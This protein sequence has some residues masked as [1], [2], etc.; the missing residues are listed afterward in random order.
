MNVRTPVS[1]EGARALPLWARAADL[2]AIALFL[3]GCY[4]A[5]EGGFVARA[6][7][8]RIAL[9]SEWR[10]FAWTA[11]FVLLRH[12][13]V[14][15]RPLWERLGDGLRRVAHVLAPRAEELWLADRDPAAARSRTW[16]LRYGAAIVL[17]FAA[18]TVLMTYPQVLGLDRAVTPDYGDPLLSTWR[19]AWFAHQLPHDPLHLFDANIFYPERF[20]L[21]FSDAM[22]VPS[23]MVAPLVWLG[24]PQLLAYNLLLLSAFALS[25]ATMFVLVRSLT[26]HT[27]AALVAGFI[28]AF[29]PYRFMHYAHL[30]LQMAQWMPLGLCALHR[31]FDRGRIRDGVLTG[32]FIALQTLSSIYYGI[33][34]AT[35]LVPV[36]AVLWFGAQP[37]A[38]RRAVK[39]LAIAVVLSGVLVAPLA[40]PYFAARKAVGERP[41]QEIE[42]YS[43][44][45]KNYLAAHSR[46]AL[47]G[48][49]TAKWGAQERELFQGIV[50]PALA[51]VALWPP[52]STARLAY[53]AGLAVAFDLSLGFNGVLYPWLHAYALPYRG[54]RVPAR[55]AILVGFSLAV[56]AGF[57]VARLSRRVGS[58]WAPALVA[59]ALVLVFVEY[60]SNLTLK[61]VWKSPPPVYDV[62]PLDQRTVILE[63]PLIRPDISLE[64]YYMYFSTFRWRMLVNGYSGFQPDSYAAL[65]ELMEDFPDPGSIAELRRR[66]VEYVI[67]HGAF[68]NALDYS[69]VV[70]RMDESRHFELVRPF[71]WEG[72]ETR[73]YR[74][75]AAERSDES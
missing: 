71:R 33:F 52:L 32:L 17:G 43:A 60:R 75:L 72:R 62:L 18:L 66:K 39:P 31:T 29:L 35:F 48:E 38:R 20:T 27:G 44:T 10:L 37:A 68:Y 21:A 65:V 36:G 34:F 58:R 11:G 5:A 64:P 2:L 47:L 46:N 55:M 22:L 61:E 13:F 41:T 59:A 1:D 15:Q 67:V 19:L 42:F 69:R 3:L 4:V 26:R 70:R 40:V 14:R 74:L 49:V 63:L 51:V 53:G 8:L 57:A 16:R 50:V 24:V 7:G 12:L 73:L 6:I 56:L 30:E 9:R 28:F 45:P 25:G 54:L 23:A